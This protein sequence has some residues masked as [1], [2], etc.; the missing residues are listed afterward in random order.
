MSSKVKRSK[1]LLVKRTH[2]HLQVRYTQCI[3]PYIFIL[4]FF[5]KACN[6]LKPTWTFNA[7]SLPSCNTPLWTC[8][9][10]AAAK[11]LSSNE[12]SLLFQSLPNSL[13]ITFYNINIMLLL[14]IIFTL[15]TKNLISNVMVSVLTLSELAL[16]KSN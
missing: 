12:A 13:L 5:P 3:L 16:Q 10:D 15:P 9:I 7:T 2:D 11:G 4:C 1:D 6:E 14:Y 8:P